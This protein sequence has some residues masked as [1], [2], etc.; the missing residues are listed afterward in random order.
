[1]NLCFFSILIIK[2]NSN[3]KKKRKEKKEKKTTK[4][5]RERARARENKREQRKMS[6]DN[7]LSISVV[8]TTLIDEGNYI[9][10]LLIMYFVYSLILFLNRNTKS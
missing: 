4:R 9:V 5:E 7:G 3:V 8:G 1:M 6:T 10:N 2:K